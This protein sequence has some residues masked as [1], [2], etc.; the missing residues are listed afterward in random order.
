VR[1][2]TVVKTRLFLVI[3]F[4]SIA[5]TPYAVLAQKE[6]EKENVLLHP[7]KFYKKFLPRLR[8][9]RNPPDSS[10]IKSYPNYL[11]VEMHILSPAIRMDIHSRMPKPEN[12]DPSSKFRT[13]I[14]DVIGFSASYRFIS[15]GF[16]FLSKSGMNTHQDYAPSRYRTATIKYNSAAYALQ[17][18]YVRIQGFT[19]INQS[20]RIDPNPVY[21]QRPD[22]VNKEFQ[23]E[24][25]YNLSW[26]KYSYIAP[27][28]FAQRQIKSHAG[29][30]LKVG[31]YYN[32]VSSNSAIVNQRQ[33]PYYGDFNDV[34]I[35]RSVSIRVAPGV[36]GNLVFLK[37]IYLSLAAFTSFDLYYYK[38]LKTPDEKA[39]RKQ[40]F[41]F[42]LDG[43]ASLGYQSRRL[44]A[45]LRYEAERR[46]GVLHSMNMN[47]IY[48]Y[49]GI[50]LGYR[51]DTPR[52]V[53][54]VYKKTMPPG[55]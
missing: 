49:T 30:L 14:S 32:Q 2:P 42:M 23:F 22:M 55:M 15:V 17:F 16:A 37:R 34:K 29:F 25:L 7:D 38:Y 10:F 24:G 35:I 3:A 46:A 44:Y 21:T 20:N 6:K 4:F 54:K 47:T 40:A 36:G 27:L 5:W 18:R 52:L 12:V 53:K 8:V 39:D 28:T 26:K 11:S 19:D 43:K 33:Q 1:V 31:A 13:N 50:E 41:V 48:T 45:G 51:F 9:K